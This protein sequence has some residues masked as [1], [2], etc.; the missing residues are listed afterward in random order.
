MDGSEAYIVQLTGVTFSASYP[1]KGSNESKDKE[2]FVS[3]K[4][5]FPNKFKDFEITGHLTPEKG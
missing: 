3:V 4:A 2:A 5:I 1:L